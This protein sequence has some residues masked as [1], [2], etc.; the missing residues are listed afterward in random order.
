MLQEIY[1]AS[2]IYLSEPAMVLVLIFGKSKRN[3]RLVVLFPEKH[4]FYTESYKTN[5]RSALIDN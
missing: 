5:N 2:G 4:L 1:A 3:Y